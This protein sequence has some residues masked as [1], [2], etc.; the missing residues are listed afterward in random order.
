MDDP[1]GFVHRWLDAFN[2]RDWAAYGQ[3]YTEDVAYLTPGRGEPL[4]SRQAH[5]EQDQRNAGSGKLS[6]SLVVAG[7]DGRHLAVEGMFE[8]GARRSRWVA[9]LELRG[10]QIAYERLYFDRTPM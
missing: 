4:I 9:I 1:E 5:V 3:F 10:D 7:Q 2:W 8:G 6:A